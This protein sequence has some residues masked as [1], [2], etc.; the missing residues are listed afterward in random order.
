M[1]D[2]MIESELL[3]K[4]FRRRNQ[5]TI[6][7]SDVNLQVRSGEF[8]VIKGKSGAG[9]STLLNLLC[10][11]IRP[12][13][14]KIWINSR[15]I[16]DMGNA[17]LSHLLSTQA[18]IIFQN[19]NLL[20]TYSLYENMEVGLV[21]AN[22]NRAIQRELIMNSLAQFNLDGMAQRLPSE[23]SIGQQQKAAIARTLVKEP[24]I[25][26]ADEPTGSVDDDTAR[27]IIAY[28]HSLNVEKNITL[29]VTTHG[30]FP[31]NEKTRVMQ[32]HEGRLR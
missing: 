13:S 21:A 23:L 11:L 32:M 19:F 29:V 24:T 15:C 1:H 3:C 4:T 25:I 6:G 18:G 9:K 10:G 31:T 2:L 5:E 20:P 27:E 7:V 14:G 12:T 22:G 30:L 16:T 17:E 28:L 26:F 8:L